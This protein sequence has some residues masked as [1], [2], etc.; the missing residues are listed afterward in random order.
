MLSIQ[1]RCPDCGGTVVAALSEVHGVAGT[2]KVES[3][4]ALM[5]ENCKISFSRGAQ[6]NVRP[7]VSAGVS[8]SSSGSPVVVG[9]DVVGRDKIT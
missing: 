8:I 7:I 4:V 1:L 9:G 6:F 5:C 2:D 3:E